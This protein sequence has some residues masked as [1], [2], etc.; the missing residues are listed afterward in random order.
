MLT[1]LNTNQMLG[2]LCWD[3]DKPTKQTEINYKG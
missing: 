3:C 2:H 1:K